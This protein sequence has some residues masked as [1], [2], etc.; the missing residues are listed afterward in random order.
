MAPWHRGTEAC[1]AVPEVDTTLV[2]VEVDTI[3]DVR[4]KFLRDSLVGSSLYGVLSDSNPKDSK[5]SPIECPLTKSTQVHGGPVSWGASDVQQVADR[6][7]SSPVGLPVDFLRS[8]HMGHGG[9]LLRCG[10][11]G[12]PAH[13]QAPP[14]EAQKIPTKADPWVIK[15]RSA[16]ALIAASTGIRHGTL[17]RTWRRSREASTGCTFQA[18][19]GTQVFPQASHQV[20]N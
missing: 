7:S 8:S 19:S 17:R 16:C 18:G 10:E 4:I 15:E 1:V 2:M 9:L 6:Q 3:G 20:S 12:Q 13:D 14:R 5:G 11:H